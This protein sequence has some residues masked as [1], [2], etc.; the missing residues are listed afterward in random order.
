[1]SAVAAGTVVWFSPSDG[2]ALVAPDAGGRD[3]FVVAGGACAGLALGAAVDYETANGP[4]GRIVAT[5]VVLA[6]PVEE[7]G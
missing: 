6:R 1:M 3:L 5:N 7:G 2:C 4:R